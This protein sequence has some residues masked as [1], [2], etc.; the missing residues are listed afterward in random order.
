MCN[1]ETWHKNTSENKGRLS[2]A[3]NWHSKEDLNSNNFN[4]ETLAKI[5]KIP[6][7]K[8]YETSLIND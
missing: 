1:E 7:F 8:F 4:K 6:L 5:S 3:K 2:I